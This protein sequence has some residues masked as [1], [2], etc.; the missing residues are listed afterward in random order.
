MKERNRIH[1]ASL[2]KDLYIIWNLEPLMPED[3]KEFLDA[4]DPAKTKKRARTTETATTRV[5]KQCKLE[6]FASLS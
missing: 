2:S 6:A 3:L 1:T 4:E 5:L